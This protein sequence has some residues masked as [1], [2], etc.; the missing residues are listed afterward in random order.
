MLEP[1]NAAVKHAIKV[2]GGVTAVTALV[3]KSRV[4]V[5]DWRRGKSLP[6]QSDWNKIRSGALRVAAITN[7]VLKKG[8]E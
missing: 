5:N 7:M 6:T 2:C 4:T 8:R 3:N 1:N